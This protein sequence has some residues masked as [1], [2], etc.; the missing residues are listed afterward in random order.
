[1]EIFPSVR[2]I[3]GSG[4]HNQQKR[5]LV[6]FDSSRIGLLVRQSPVK[7]SLADPGSVII[8]AGVSS[9]HPGLGMFVK[10]GGPLGNPPQPF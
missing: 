7:K 1:M 4:H 3:A 10:F 5:H 9:R 6:H 8:A 2:M